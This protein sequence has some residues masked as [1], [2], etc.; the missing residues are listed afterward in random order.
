METDESSLRGRG[1]NNLLF[2][3]RTREDGFPGKVETM[4]GIGQSFEGFSGWPPIDDR[5]WADREQ[6]TCH[7]SEME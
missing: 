7:G 4:K 1:I 6:K 5:T 2:H 3:L